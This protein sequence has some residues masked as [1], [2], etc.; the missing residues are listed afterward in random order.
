MLAN[1]IG[2]LSVHTYGSAK[3]LTLSANT[4]PA[5]VVMGN[6]AENF[7]FGSSDKE[8]ND[9]QYVT[10][11][12]F[13]ELFEIIVECD[14]SRFE[15][16]LNSAMA[17]SLRCDGSVD[18][19]QIDEIYS[20]MKV[21]SDTGSQELYFLGAAE[22]QERGAKG[23]LG[24]VIEGCANTIGETVD[25]RKVAPLM[26]K[27]SSMITDGAAV[28]TGEKNGLWVLFE[29]YLKSLIEAEEEF[30]L[31]PLLKIWCEVHR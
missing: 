28:N 4:F 6:L 3:R 9:F 29:K 30:I 24:A 17:I 14:R 25:K 1:K 13:R 11:T 8:Y 21:I 5:R 12:S 16:L 7:N 22:P 19:K 20:M 18:R 2:K 27:I 15:E 23:L 31:P 10:P 26:K